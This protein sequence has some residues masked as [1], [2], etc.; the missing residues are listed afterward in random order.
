MCTCSVPL[1]PT[2]TPVLVTTLISEGSL[3]VMGMNSEYRTPSHS[4]E[5]EPK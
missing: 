3:N 5:T 2:P 1:L 4:K